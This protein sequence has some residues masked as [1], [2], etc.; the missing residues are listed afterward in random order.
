MKTLKILHVV[1]TRSDLVKL[2]PLYKASRV[3]SGR[4]VQKIVHTGAH[5]TKKMFGMFLDEF[6]IEPPEF[7]LGINSH[8]YAAGISEMMRCLEVIFL[9]ERP[10][11]ILT[12]GDGLSSL[13][14]GLCAAKTDMTLAHLEAG[15]RNYV[16]LDPRE[17]RRRMIDSMA[18]YLF[19][20]SKRK[21]CGLRKEG[22]RKERIFCVG[23]IFSDYASLYKS[24]EATEKLHQYQLIKHNKIIP[25]MLVT[26]HHED[27]ISEKDSLTCVLEALQE[28]RKSFCV[29]ISLEAHTSIQ[30]KTLGLEGQL[31]KMKNVKLL[32]QMSHKDIVG[33]VKHSRFV[34]TDSLSLQDETGLM[35]VPCVVLRQT[36]ER[37]DRLTKNHQY[38]QC[39]KDKIV[40]ACLIANR[41][42]FKEKK[43]DCVDKLCVADKILDVLLAPMANK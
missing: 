19:V 30:L 24:T 32:P 25:Y 1:G 14:A 40:R 35:G 41:L 39:T 16:P 2:A 11:I 3:R 36:T 17:H 4:M 33:L 42:S 21:A 8:A 43:G 27:L 13:A 38:V 18:R 6:E 9:K 34:L 23:N 15:L 5:Y 31:S 7:S 12:L 37:D 28:L 26:F 29:L 22:I 20:C 10:Q